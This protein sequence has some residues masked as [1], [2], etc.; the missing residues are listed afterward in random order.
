M[1]LLN[2]RYVKQVLY[3]ALTI[4]SCIFVISVSTEMFNTCSTSVADIST[5]VEKLGTG[6]NCVRAIVDIPDGVAVPKDQIAI[7]S[8]C[9]HR[10][11]TGLIV[12]GTTLGSYYIECLCP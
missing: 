4:V 7:N 9:P 5:Q 6:D 11:H 12:R 2:N 3:A 10:E 1:R 8:L